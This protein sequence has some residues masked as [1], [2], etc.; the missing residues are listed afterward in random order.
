MKKKV[1]EE[2]GSRLVALLRDVTFGT[3]E[4]AKENEEGR[5]RGK[6]VERE[7]GMR[8]EGK[9][10]SKGNQLFPAF[11]SFFNFFFFF[12]FYSFL[13]YS[14]L[15]EVN[16]GTKIFR[17]AGGS[18]HHIFEE[19]IVDL[20]I[21]IQ[22]GIPRNRSNRGCQGEVDL[23]A[24]LGQIAEKVAFEV[25]GLCLDHHS[26]RWQE[27]Q[28]GQPCT[29]QPKE[30]RGLPNHLQLLSVAHC[31]KLHVLDPVLAFKLPVLLPHL[32][33]VSLD[34]L[35]HVQDPPSSTLDDQDLGDFGIRGWGKEE[36]RR[37]DVRELLE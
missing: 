14:S 3:Q 22:R 25:R 4:K 30:D 34:Q 20:V 33:R 10:G 28:V 21:S 17:D 15:K 24:K 13:F 29:M 1:G 12:F 8:K 27:H 23:V 9:E 2:K 35:I 31:L 19:I 32:L 5:K 37:D 11:S 26:L 18:I 6:E 36:V 7:E 16:F